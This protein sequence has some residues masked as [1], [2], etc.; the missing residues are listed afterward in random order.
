LKNDF[1]YQSIVTETPNHSKDL[2]VANKQ[3]S[4]SPTFTSS[5]CRCRSQKGKKILMTWQSF[6]TFGICAGK[7][8]WWNQPQ[9]SISSMFYEQLLR[10]QIPKAEN[11]TGN[12]TVIFALLGSAHVKAAR[13]SLMKLTPD[14][15]FINTLCAAFTHADPKST[16]KTGN[17][18]PFQ[19][20]CV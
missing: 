3:G 2:N 13:R 7:S 18:L 6:C 1:L 15:N 9:G 19:D 11:F 17:F 4:I 10:T 8:C 20:L 5:F 14:V 12:M 16:K